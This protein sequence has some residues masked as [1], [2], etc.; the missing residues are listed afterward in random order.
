MLTD[1]IV[2]EPFYI[3]RLLAVRLIRGVIF[4]VA[5]VTA[6]AFAL[7]VAAGTIIDIL[8]VGWSLPS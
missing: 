3:P 5:V 6:L 7:L 2:I 4:L 1:P 8:I